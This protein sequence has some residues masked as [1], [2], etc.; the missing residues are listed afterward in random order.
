[1]G[2]FRYN[3]LRRFYMD[4]HKNYHHFGPG[5]LP[6]LALGALIIPIIIWLDVIALLW[7]DGGILPGSVHDFHNNLPAAGQLFLWLGLPVIAGILAGISLV[8]GIAPRLSRWIICASVI[9]S[10]LA[11]LAAMRPQ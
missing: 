4:Y 5:L 8:K 11:I 7:F 10:V 1:M 3:I 6:R 2:D 9:L